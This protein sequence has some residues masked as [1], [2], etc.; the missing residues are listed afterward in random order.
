MYVEIT[1]PEGIRERIESDPGTGPESSHSHSEARGGLYA[2]LRVRL[3]R[4]PEKH[5]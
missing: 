2:P 4:L 3:Q 1:F 5:S